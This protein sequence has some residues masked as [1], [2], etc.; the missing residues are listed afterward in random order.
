MYR[1][2][3]ATCYRERLAIDR[4]PTITNFES[5]TDGASYTPRL[6][7]SSNLPGVCIGVHRLEVFRTNAQ[8]KLT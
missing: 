2:G 6:T 1:G 3:G 8:I 5:A 7:V 4:K